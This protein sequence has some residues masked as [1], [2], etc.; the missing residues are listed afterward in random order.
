VTIVEKLG[1][2]VA[3]AKAASDEE[4]ELFDLRNRAFTYPR[5]LAQHAV[6][7]G[8]ISIIPRFS[9]HYHNHLPKKK[10]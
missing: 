10:F 4:N 1:R 9:D 8:E 3:N 7:T 6:V 5:S 2:L